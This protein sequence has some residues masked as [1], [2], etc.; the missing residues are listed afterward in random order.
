LADLSGKVAIVTGGSKGIGA[1]IAFQLARAGA[2]VA[3]NYSS[4]RAGAERA[5]ERIVA[6]G[7][8]A[9]AVAADVSSEADVARMVALT[10]ETFGR[11]DI[12]VNNAAY[13][14]FGPVE[15]ITLE[16]YRRH[17]DVNV[18]GAI[19]LTR[20]AS[21]HFKEG[22]SIINI[23][24]AGVLNPLP[25]ALLYAGSKAAL[26]RITRF[27]SKE[28]GPRQIRVNMVL[29]GATDTEGNR[30][31]GTMD[32]PEAVQALVEHT[33]LRRFGSPEDVAPAVVFLASDDAAWITG[34]L[35][36][37]SGGF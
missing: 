10:V 24:S 29:P 32:N 19:L 6:L 22:G 30:R 2:A 26:E 15:E 25:N 37:A 35:L 11:L 5:V 13:F 1:E 36:E 8:K 23:G 18:L 7:G 34:T 16:D 14:S 17:F 4:D 33:A 20:E 3:V 12:V 21:P 28:L 31:I 27:L 9:M